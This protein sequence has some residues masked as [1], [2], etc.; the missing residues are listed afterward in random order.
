M[1]KSTIQ[2]LLDPKDLDFL[3]NIIEKHKLKN[4]SDAVRTIIARYKGMEDWIMNRKKVEEKA[5]EL[6]EAKVIVY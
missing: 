5:K 6:R 2:V 3:S 4:N 1:A